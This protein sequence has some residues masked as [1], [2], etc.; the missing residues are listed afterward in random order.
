[1]IT[2]RQISAGEQVVIGEV[3]RKLNIGAIPVHGVLNQF[4]PQRH[5][6][7]IPNA[8]TNDVLFSRGCYSDLP[9]VGCPALENG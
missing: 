1:M 5:V 8:R 3:V 2:R 7:S 6:V 9:D 4:Q